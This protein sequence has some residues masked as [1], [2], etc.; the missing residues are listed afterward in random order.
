MTDTTV[1]INPNVSTVN[2]STPITS[3]ISIG[4]QGPPGT[5]APITIV[6][7]ID[8]GGHRGVIL[9]NGTGIYADS[10]DLSHAG[11]L[12]GITSGAIT[13]GSSG[14]II[15][16]GE[17]DGFSGLTPNAKVYLQPNGVISSTFPS[18]GFVQQVGIA[19]NATK[20]LI[21]IQPS[22]VLG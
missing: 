19:E 13:S 11:K 6:A 14:V 21:N 5:S 22:L 8:L 15:T 7:G 9:N 20:I 17:L 10:S 4:T 16:A 3:I 2:L 18:S 12:V 1:I